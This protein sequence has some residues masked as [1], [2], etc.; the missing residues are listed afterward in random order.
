MAR[1]I[2]PI[3][4]DSIPGTFQPVAI[5]YTN[6]ARAWMLRNRKKQPNFFYLFIYALERS[7]SLKYNIES[8]ITANNEREIILT[9]VTVA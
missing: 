9:F 7:V 1:N 6:Y 5:I 8:I 3:H 4:R 2:S